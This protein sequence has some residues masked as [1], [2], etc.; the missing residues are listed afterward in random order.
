MARGWESKDVENQI[1]DWASDHARASQ[2]IS[3]EEQQLRDLELTRTR[4]QREI[5]ESSNERL[6]Q[7]KQLA[8]E[9]VEKQ[10]AALKVSKKA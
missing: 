7:Q 8:L 10:I 2:T 9:H 4:L 6:R 5:A 3:A 1:E